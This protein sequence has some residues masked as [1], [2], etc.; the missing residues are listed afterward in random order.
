MQTKFTVLIYSDKGN[1]QAGEVN[2]DVAE[3]LNAKQKELEMQK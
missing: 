3:F 1:K 2:Y